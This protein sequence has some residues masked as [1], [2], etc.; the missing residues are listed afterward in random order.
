LEKNRAE[1]KQKQ[2][3]YVRKMQGTDWKEF[4]KEKKEAKKR[5]RLEWM[6]KEDD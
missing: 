2:A 1:T 6:L 4:N 5:K 3:E